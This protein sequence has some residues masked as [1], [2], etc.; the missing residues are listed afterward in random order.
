M[1]ASKRQRTGTP[2]PSPT[3]RRRRRNC[4]WWSGTKLHP[5]VTFLSFL[6]G[7]TALG[8]DIVGGIREHKGCSTIPS[9]WMPVL[10]YLAA[11]GRFSSGECVTKQFSYH[12][13]VLFFHHTT[14]SI[15]LHT[16]TKI[17]QWKPKTNTIHIGVTVELMVKYKWIA[18]TANI[19]TKQKLL[20]L[21]LLL[22]QLLLLQLLYSS[23]TTYLLLYPCDSAQ[24][25]QSGTRLFIFSFF[26]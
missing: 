9:C 6:L 23:T 19:I 26:G 7:P 3:I 25:R 18:S 5:P 22:L 16:E 21:L 2:L 8:D 20:L 14:S 17:I 24:T 15:T 1:L 10:R 11:S 4:K 12:R 13:F